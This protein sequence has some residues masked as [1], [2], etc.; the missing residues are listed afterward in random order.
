MVLFVT[1]TVGYSDTGHVEEET[2][3][4]AE[5]A[6][7]SAPKSDTIVDWWSPRYLIG[8]GL[9]AAGTTGYIVGDQMSAREQPRMGPSY[10]RENPTEIFDVDTVGKS[11]RE[12]DTI[13]IAWVHGFQFGA[14]A[15][16]AAIEGSQWRAGYGSGQRFHDTL[17]GYLEASTLTAAVTSLVKPRIGRLR[18]DFGER[19][20][21]YHCTQT[22]ADYGTH[23]DGYRDK[24]LHESP[25]RAQRRLNDGKKSFFSGH[26]SNS[27]AI[28]VY[29]SLIIGG[30]YVWGI[31]DSPRSRLP[32]IAAQIALMGT[33]A[34]ISTTR[35][36]D[37]RHHRSD[38]I[39][40][41]AVGTAFANF[42]YWR[43]FDGRGALRMSDEHE[44]ERERVSLSVQPSV[45]MSGLS[46]TVRH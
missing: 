41:A 8:Y 44:A 16:L 12:G 43:R 15:F 10:D 3:A 22:G 7:T 18:P 17:I 31:A 39:A 1:P 24:P 9:I 27:F 36:T 4:A 34:F 32:G 2:I 45:D 35:V 46:L 5:N 38:V 14:A 6:G 20:R 40:G 37:G 21:R 13:P 19:A 30:H 33:A 29:T 23:C 26:A 42:S 11:F 25:R 28:S